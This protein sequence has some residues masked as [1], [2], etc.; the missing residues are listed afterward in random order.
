LRFCRVVFDVDVVAGEVHYQIS[1]AASAEGG[2]PRNFFFDVDFGAAVGTMDYY[3]K[4]GLG[5]ASLLIV[6]VPH[7]TNFP[8]L[9][10]FGFMHRNL[11][12]SET[13]QI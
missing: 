6:C 7:P 1:F 11:T 13:P 2:V 4:C 3:H 8:S 5:Y 12:P 9:I 10:F